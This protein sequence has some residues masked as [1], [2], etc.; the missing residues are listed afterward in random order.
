M[1]DVDIDVSPEG[2]EEVIA[3]IIEMYGADHVARIIAFSELAAKGAVRDVGKAICAAPT[4]INT[5]S[6]RIP[7]GPGITLRDLLDHDHTLKKMYEDDPEAKR[8]LELLSIL[9]RLPILSRYRRIAMDISSLSLIWQVL[10]LS[11]C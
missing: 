9:N 6:K 10:K 8:L 3:H 11:V 1:P 2:R 7:A 4:L 5:I